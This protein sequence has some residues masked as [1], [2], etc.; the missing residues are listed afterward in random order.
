MLKST[1]GCNSFAGVQAEHFLE[2][3][4]EMLEQSENIVA[5]MYYILSICDHLEWLCALDHE[6]LLASR[7]QKWIK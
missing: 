6:R 4:T 7:C 2:H 3:D 1:P 5:D